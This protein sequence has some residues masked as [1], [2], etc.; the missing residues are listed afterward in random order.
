MI[1]TRKMRR[2]NQIQSKNL[3]SN[4][5]VDSIFSSAEKTCD[6]KDR[7]N[8]IQRVTNLEEENI[9]ILA[10]LDEIQI[11]LNSTKLD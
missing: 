9:R 1:E 10:K 3:R 11:A 6:I 2:N 7:N 8:T 4:A 5:T